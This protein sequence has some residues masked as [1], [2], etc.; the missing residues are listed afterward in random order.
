MSCLLSESNVAQI[1]Q[2][3]RDRLQAACGMARI[4]LLFNGYPALIAAAGKKV[5]M[6]G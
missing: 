6:A 5:L 4:T 3:L 2:A 1:A